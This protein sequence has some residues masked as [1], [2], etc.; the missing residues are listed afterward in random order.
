MKAK[1]Y[2]RSV[3]SRVEKSV[4]VQMTGNS[5]GGNENLSF[6]KHGLA[7]RA[8]RSPEGS[9]RL[10]DYGSGVIRSRIINEKKDRVDSEGKDGSSYLGVSSML[11]QKNM[12]SKVIKFISE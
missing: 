6:I 1:P 3:D 2:E 12:G 11:H 9:S 10:K 5:D 8:V 7:G 4:K